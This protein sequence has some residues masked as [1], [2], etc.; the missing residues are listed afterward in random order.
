MDENN[1][2]TLREFSAAGPCLTLGRVVRETPNFWFYRKWRGGP[3]FDPAQTRAGKIPGRHT[4][5]CPSCR[6]HP[7]TQYPNGYQD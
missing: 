5:P 6:D 2:K 1:G 7:R 3:D 4:D